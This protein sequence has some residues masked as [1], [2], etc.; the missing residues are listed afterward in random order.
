MTADGPAR[1]RRAFGRAARRARR[2][3]ARRAAR[4]RSG[5]WPSTAARSSG[6]PTASPR[7]PPTRPG[8]SLYVVVH[9]PPDPPHFPST[10]VRRDAVAGAARVPRPRR[11]R[12]HRPRL[13]AR[14]HVH[15]AAAR[16]AQPRAR[17][18][19]RRGVVGR[20]AGLRGRH[21][22]RAIPR[23]LRGLHPDNPVN[24]PPDGGVQLEL[25]PRVRGLGPR[26]ADWAGDGFVP[27]TG[28]ARSTRWRRG[29]PAPMDVTASGREALDDPAAAAIAA[30]ADAVVEA[31]RAA[32]PE[33]D[34]VDAEAP[35]APEAG[36]RHVAA[37][38]LGVRRRRCA[39]R[40]RRGRR[41]P[42]SAATPTPRSGCRAGARR[43]RR[44]S[45]RRSTRS[46]GPRTRTWRCRSS[47]AN[48]PAPRGLAVDLAALRAVVVGVEHEARARR[49]R[50]R[51]RSG[52]RA[53][54]RR[55]PWP[56]PSRSARST[57]ADAGVVVPRA[58]TARSGRRRRRRRR[59]R[60]S[61]TARGGRTARRRRRRH[62][63]SRS[64]MRSAPRMYGC[65]D[66]GDQRPSRRAGGSS[67]R[68]PPTPGA[69]RAPSR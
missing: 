30:V 44:R 13:R 14:R 18:R 10:D 24:V 27:P 31:A 55:R 35:A 49:R 11:R 47:Q 58:A 60:P 8:A 20:A 56:G 9:P 28:G 26:W 2:R 52:R 50:G 61:R 57:P 65:S 64:A 12:R 41:A 19:P 45:R 37:G 21:R 62:D 32:L 51:A 46:I 43:S 67:R 39:G 6:R 22:P 40:G 68:S 69:R 4:P 53:G 1:P 33:L 59:A 66:L 54:R 42:R 5:S 34:L 48:T 15:V 7:P 17:R 16:R 3:R 36:P 29:R 23:E 38:E 25:P 63:Q